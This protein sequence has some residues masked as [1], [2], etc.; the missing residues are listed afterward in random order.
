VARARRWAKVTAGAMVAAEPP[1]DDGT[2]GSYASPVEVSWDTMPLSDRIDLLQQQSQRLGIDDR[3]VDWKA[4]LARREVDTL[5]VTSRGSRIEQRFRFVYPG[6]EATANEGTNTHTRTF[7]GNAYCGQGGAEVLGRHGFGDAATTIAE[8]ALEL[9]DA[10]NCPTGL[11]DVLLAPDQMILQIHESIGHRSNSTGSS[12]T[13]ATMPAR[14]S[15]RPTC[16]ARSGTG[17]HC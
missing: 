17:P 10:P 6:L 12:A 13:S 9:L 1:P 5:L 11:M 4:T 3:I 2:A 15:S 16:S 7:G 8:Q 14:A